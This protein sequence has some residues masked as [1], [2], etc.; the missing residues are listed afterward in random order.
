MGVMLSL[1]GSGLLFAALHG[2]LVRSVPAVLEPEPVLGVF[3]DD[4]LDGFRHLPRQAFVILFR[5]ARVL[6]I[7]GFL[8]EELELIAGAGS[9][10][11]GAEKADAVTLLSLDDLQTYRKDLKDYRQNAWLKDAGEMPGT[12]AWMGPGGTGYAYGYPVGSD[13]LRVYPVI[14]VEA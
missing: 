7:E 14:T 3:P 4:F 9:G 6:V 11:T 5:M 2:L 8:D 12:A 10:E 13:L 1:A